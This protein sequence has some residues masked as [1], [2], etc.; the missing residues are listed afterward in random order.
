MID[1]YAY[2]K[3]NDIDIIN[4]FKQV[5]SY[6][7]FIQILVKL[8]NC[9][10]YLELG[11]ADGANIYKIRDYV[12]RCV[13]VDIE[14]RLIDKNRIEYNAMTT[15]DYFNKCSEYFDIIFIDANHDWPFVRRDF[16]NSLK[17]LN[18]FGII[19]LHDTDPIIPEMLSPGFCSNSYH[20]TDYI[21]ANHTELNVMTLPICDMGLTIVMR[22][23]DRRVLKF[24]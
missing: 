2:G 5:E 17:I 13:G 7:I 20:I 8:T 11:V 19:L 3:Y 6:S 16:E 1:R 4:N 23:K 22:K 21:Y 9:K 10:K 24:L 15:D 18:E 14:D 12:E